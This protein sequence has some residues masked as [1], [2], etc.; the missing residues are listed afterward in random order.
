VGWL[1]GNIDVLNEDS[2]QGPFERP[3]TLAVGE[4]DDP[5]PYLASAR[6][7]GPVQSEWPLPVHTGASHSAESASF[8][9]LGH[10]EVVAALRDHET[11]SSRLLSEIM[12]PHF[13]DTIIAMDEPDHRARREL[14]AP[15][16]RPRFL[17]R[18]EDTLVR[19]VVDQLIDSFVSDGRVDLID[20]FTFAFPVRVIARILGLPDRDWRQF[21][22]WS[23]DLINIFLDWD[24]GISALG[25]LRPYLAAQ[26]AQRRAEPRNDLISELVTAEV[27]GAR[28][29]DEAIFAFIRLLLPAGI[30]TTYRS[31]GNLLFALLMNPNQLDEIRR[32]PELRVAAIEE[33]LRWETPFLMVVRRSTRDSSLGGVH[34]P[35]GRELSVFVGSAN[36]DEQRYSDPDRFDIHRPPRPHVAFGSGP[37]TCLGMHLTRLESRVA[38]D[39]LLGRLPH[40]RLD[41]DATRPRITGTVFR[42]PDSLPVRLGG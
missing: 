32:H 24:R 17:D 31:L 11:Y 6:R 2:G 28:L 38:L 12:G 20:R 25:A 40:L 9:V 29:D 22:R 1:G 26:I 14:V 21:Q 33:G 41:P 8:C 27:D 7:N 10:N 3:G 16:F 18:W 23:I 30:E 36:R 13:A 39:A 34:I 4:V 19:P 42:S 35:A 5:Y 37:H 15:A